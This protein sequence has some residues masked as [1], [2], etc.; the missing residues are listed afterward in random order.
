MPVTV[1]A[2]VPAALTDPLPRPAAPPRNCRYRNG[3]PAVC[4]LDALLWI[5]EP[6]RVIDRAD[7]DRA[8]TKGLGDAAAGLTSR[9][10]R[11]KP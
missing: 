10:G 9:D 5:V 2:P 1:Y 7:E 3:Q 11:G 4:A 8:T 6:L